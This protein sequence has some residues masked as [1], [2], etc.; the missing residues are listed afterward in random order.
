VQPARADPVLAGRVF[1]KLLKGE[2]N[3]L[4]NL[5]QAQ[6]EHSTAEPETRPDV[7]I[8]RPPLFR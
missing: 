4:G 6:A 7:L 2:T 3:C 5:L 8:D 1:L